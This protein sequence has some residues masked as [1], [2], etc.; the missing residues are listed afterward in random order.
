[1]DK[2]LTEKQSQIFIYG[3]SWIQKNSKSD[4]EF[5]QRK[6]V[7]CSEG[8]ENR[9]NS[10]AVNETKGKLFVADWI[11]NINSSNFPELNRSFKESFDPFGFNDVSANY[12]V[13]FEKLNNLVKTLDA[14]S[15]DPFVTNIEF[16]D[17]PKTVFKFYD[18]L[19]T[20]RPVGI[21]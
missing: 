4:I 15:I 17:M 3:L 12:P 19:G 2:I 5:D 16:L 8:F 11:K 21:I 13:V 10:K 18:Y 20:M 14:P 6:I 7:F 9:E 1:M